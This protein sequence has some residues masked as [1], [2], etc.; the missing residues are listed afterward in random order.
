MSSLDS[1]APET[2]K[3]GQEGGGASPVVEYE[4]AWRLRL[5]VRTRPSQGRNTSSTLVGVTQTEKN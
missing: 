4:V 5:M 1:G 3:V 2:V